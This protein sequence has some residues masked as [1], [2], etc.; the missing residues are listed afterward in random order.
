MLA[1][2]AGFAAFLAARANALGGFPEP[3]QRLVD[4]RL[5]ASRCS[6]LS[7]IFLYFFFAIVPLEQSSDLANLF[8][9]IV[10]RE[11]RR[12]ELA[13]RDKR[14]GLHRDRIDRDRAAHKTPIQ[15]RPLASTGANRRRPL[16]G[17]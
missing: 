8:K 5:P 9:Q 2:L 16:S 6:L 17:D 13:P 12:F 15:T 4:V 1:G 14:F 10:Q 7:Q 11:D 3:A